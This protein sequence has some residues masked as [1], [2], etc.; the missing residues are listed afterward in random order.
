M[1]DAPGWDAIDGALQKIYGDT[2]PA[3]FATIIKWRLGGPD[4]LDGLSA[5]RS[6]RGGPHWHIVSYGLSELYAKE[7]DDTTTSGYGFELTIR[8]RRG[9]DELAPPN[10]A[11]NLLQELARYVFETGNV[12]EPGHNL[13][14][15]GPL[16]GDPQTQVTGALFAEDPELPAMDTKNGRVGFVQV[17]GV[18]GDELRAATG[19]K[20]SRFL[21]VLGQSLPLWI[22]DVGRKSI[23]L[24]PAIA[25]LVE[26]RADEEGSSM[27]ALYVDVLRF[28]KKGLVSRTLEITM[29][30]QAVELVAR[31]M[32]RRLLFRQPL[33]LL[34]RGTRVAF[35]PADSPSW[36]M[37]A[38][39]LVI[40]VPADLARAIAAEL[41]PR[42]GRY[43]FA[44]LPGVSIQV[45]KTEIKDAAGKVVRVLG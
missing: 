18:T 1:D 9:P 23:L 10:W 44:P 2:E 26:R 38:D 31:M 35:T 40:S 33:V 17:V 13:D 21:E 30:A 20:A 16:G 6:E 12:F 37:D 45:E 8:V 4:P 25:E 34:S 5:F 11:L 22:T 27:G 14:L 3:H 15:N 43:S 7:L 32:R 29:G 39:G 41:Q 28:A 19:W 42:A 36:K 24:D